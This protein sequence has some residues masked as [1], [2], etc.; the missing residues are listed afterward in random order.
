[1][2]VLF[3]SSDEDSSDEPTARRDHDRGGDAVYHGNLPGGFARVRGH[4][5]RA[6]EDPPNTSPGTGFARV[7][8]DDAPTRCAL[9]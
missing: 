1:M 7:T 4:L 3:S 9:R 2:P 6:A 8:F 5:E